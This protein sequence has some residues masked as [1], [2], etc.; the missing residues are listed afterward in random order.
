M[1]RRRPHLVSAAGRAAAPLSVDDHLGSAA[2]RAAAPLSVDDHLILAVDDHLGSA[3]SGATT[4]L[5]PIILMPIWVQAWIAV[6]PLTEP[7]RKSG[8]RNVA[9]R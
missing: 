4:P 9:R 7:G 1:H 2:G 6:C 5:V 3:A 8:G